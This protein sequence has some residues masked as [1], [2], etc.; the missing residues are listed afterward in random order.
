MGIPVLRVYFFKCVSAAIVFLLIGFWLSPMVGKM[1]VPASLARDNIHQILFFRGAGSMNI[2]RA[3]NKEQMVFVIDKCPKA[4][5]AWKVCYESAD[6][7]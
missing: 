7:P 5:K 2:Y 6:P 1:E 3:F 4:G